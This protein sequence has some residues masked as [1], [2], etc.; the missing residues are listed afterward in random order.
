MKELNQLLTA[1]EVAE[2]T[3]YPYQQLWTY[4]KRGTL[5]PADHRV[6]NK[7]VWEKQTID[8]WVENRSK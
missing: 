7:P 8:Q 3:G 4:L 2:L 1:K 5:P 6:G